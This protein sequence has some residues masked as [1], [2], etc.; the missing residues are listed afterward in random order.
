[1]RLLL[2]P[3]LVLLPSVAF[4]Q[5]LEGVPAPKPP[6][7]GETVDEAWMRAKLDAWV[8]R[9]R[10]ELIAYF[11]RPKDQWPNG[12]FWQV[13][14]VEGSGKDACEYWFDTDVQERVRAWYWKGDCS[15]A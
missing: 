4:A 9:T 11:G 8:G 6:P 15:G 2:V 13:L 1:M 14:F 7:K 10:T 12:E 3:L 5:A